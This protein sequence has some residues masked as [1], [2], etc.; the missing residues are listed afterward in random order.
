MG[1]IS[2]ELILNNQNFIT[3]FST[4]KTPEYTCPGCKKTSLKKDELFVQANAVSERGRN[5]DW[6]EPEHEEYVF[7][8]S[9]KCSDC[10]ELVF[11]HGD[12]FLEE[13]YDVDENENWSREWVKYL[14][15]KSF[16]PSLK[17]IDC[18]P[19]TPKVV[20]VHLEAASALYYSHPPACCNSLRM[21]AEEVLT[22]LGVPEPPPGEFVSFG[23]R[24]KNL[25]EESNSYNLL[26][27]IR[28]LGNEGSHSGSS[29]TH[30]DAEDAF[31]VMDLLLEECYSDR[32]KKIH[33]LAAA[34]R[35][36]KGPVGSRSL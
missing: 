26:D 19:A 29:I 20:Q 5:E 3:V 34:I 15:P 27:A 22:S 35:Q 33:E 14:R 32:Q 25:P 16:F 4:E 23:N 24:I 30:K 1:R 18:P 11:V 7:R 8:L 6:W 9:L 21:A 28:W 10:N 36:H 12:G 13:E 17:F 2:M 31:Q